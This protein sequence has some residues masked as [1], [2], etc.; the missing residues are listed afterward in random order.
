MAAVAIIARNTFENNNTRVVPYDDG[1]PNA[2]PMRDRTAKE[3][4]GP[5]AEWTVDE[6]AAWL[7]VNGQKTISEKARSAQID[8]SV[9]I[10]LDAEGWKELGVT[11]AI[12]RAKLL[13]AVKKAAL[14]E[15]SG[16]PLSNVVT[17]QGAEPT[18]RS[19]AAEKRLV[20]HFVPN[21]GKQ[22]TPDM[23]AEHTPGWALCIANANRNPADVKQHYLRFMGVYN[24]ID[25]LVLTINMAYLITADLSG[26]GPNSWCSVVL[27]TCQGTSSILA[28]VGMIASTIL[29]NTASGVSDANFVVFGKLPST[30]RYMRLIND[31]SIFAGQFTVISTFFFLYRICVDHMNPIWVMY[32]GGP[33]IEGRWYYA[34]PALIVPL[35]AMLYNM[36][37]VWMPNLIQCT[38]QAMYGGL[39]SSDPIQPLADDPTWAHRCSSEQ[40]AEHVNASAIATAR[41][42]KPAACEAEAAQMYA[43]QTVAAMGGTTDEGLGILNGAAAGEAGSLLSSIVALA[44][45]AGGWRRGSTQKGS[46]ANPLMGARDS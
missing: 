34:L 37:M 16:E 14:A 31:V 38:H 45:G 7:M 11:S 6:V 40:L 29:Y 23:G 3:A 27:L 46:R 20:N 15:A 8:G 36:F 18:K 17:Q 22:R 4:T 1:S 13:A 33:E 41:A 42:T 43:E 32:P 30:L 10:E 24:V 12:E 9:L 28:G 39:F 2:S 35:I 21:C 44:G 26:I 25:L 19:K 5:L